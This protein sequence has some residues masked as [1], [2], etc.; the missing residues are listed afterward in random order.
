MDLTAAATLFAWLDREVW[1]VTAQAGD[2]R[3]GM[4]ATFVSQASIVPGLPRLSVGI[5]KSHYTFDLIESSRAF[6]LHLLSED[7]LELVWR[8]GLESGRDLDKFAGLEI[9][10]ASTGSPLLTA[11]VGWLDCRVETSLDIGDRV[12]YVVEVLEGQVTNFAP[13]LTTSRLMELAPKARLAEMQRNRQRDSYLDAEAI[14]A[15]RNQGREGNTPE[16]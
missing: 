14:L 13:P 12:I 2:R 1:L 9:T 5:A 6:A 4:I 16:T 15:W 8:F 7:Q 3:S 10:T 11:A